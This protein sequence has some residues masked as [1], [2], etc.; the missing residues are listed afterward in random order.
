MATELGDEVA[1]R[2]R[3]RLSHLQQNRPA[4]AGTL[5]CG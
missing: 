5:R 4:I 3:D 1:S 2:R